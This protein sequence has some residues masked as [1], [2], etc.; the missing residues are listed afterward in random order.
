MHGMRAPNERPET[1]TAKADQFVGSMLRLARTEAAQGQS[2]AALR[3]LGIA[4]HTVMDETSPYHRD[5]GGNPLP[6]GAS[7]SS[8]ASHV[9]AES[10]R[11]WAPASALGV[12][13]DKLLQMYKYVFPE[14]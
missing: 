3:D 6:W 12:T 2:E 4:M 14:H 10:S 7:F 9:A 13:T 1:A 8:E 5:T 11:I